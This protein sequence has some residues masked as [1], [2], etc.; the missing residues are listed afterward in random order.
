MIDSVLTSDSGDYTCLATNEVGSATRRVKLVVYGKM[1]SCGWKR[2]QGWAGA[3]LGCEE[4]QQLHLSLQSWLGF[5][6]ASR[7][8]LCLSKTNSSI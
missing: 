7:C 5:L 4:A 1:V 6:Q 8:C 2:P 3:G